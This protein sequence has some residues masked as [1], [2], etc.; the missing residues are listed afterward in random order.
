MFI[1]CK[2]F[3]EKHYEKFSKLN[4]STPV[5]NHAANLIKT[6]LQYKSYDVTPLWIRQAGKSG[7]PH[8]SIA[9]KFEAGPLGPRISLDPE[10]LISGNT[11]AVLE[12]L[13][14]QLAIKYPDITSTA[15]KW[16]KIRRDLTPTIENCF[17]TFLSQSS[18][19]EKDNSDASQP[20]IV[21]E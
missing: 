13:A 5:L 15:T 1:R 11:E 14:T 16:N 17:K 21:D 20:V 10:K 6:V 19:K 18:R 4:A 7:Q 9:L 3:N 2:K 8:L 12:Y